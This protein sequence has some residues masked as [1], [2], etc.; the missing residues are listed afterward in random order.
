MANGA[1]YTAVDLAGNT[2]KVDSDS[3]KAIRHYNTGRFGN[4]NFQYVDEDKMVAGENYII[5]GDDPTDTA[6]GGGLTNIN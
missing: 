4:S 5:K 3:A 2:Y 1:G 6:T